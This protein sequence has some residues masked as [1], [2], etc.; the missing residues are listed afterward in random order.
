MIYL[1]ARNSFFDNILEVIKVLE[2]YEPAISR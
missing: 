2:D 1:E